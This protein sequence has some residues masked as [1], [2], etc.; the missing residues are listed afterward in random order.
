MSKSMTLTAA[1]PFQFQNNNE[2]SENASAAGSQES[3]RDKKKSYPVD[4]PPAYFQADLFS[5]MEV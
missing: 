1:L 2:D 3:A 5:Q 4:P